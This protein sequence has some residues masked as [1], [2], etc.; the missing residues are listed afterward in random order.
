MLR[1]RLAHPELFASIDCRHCLRTHRLPH[2]PTGHARGHRC[3]CALPRR[4][5]LT[6]NPPSTSS[7]A[8]H[9]KP[10]TEEPGA[11]VA[12]DADKHET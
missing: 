8:N 5:H 3:T 2:A 9:A 6:M 10:R 4:G 7:H 1:A 12:F 11:S